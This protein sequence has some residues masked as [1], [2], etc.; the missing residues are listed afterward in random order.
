MSLSDL[1]FRAAVHRA[2]PDKSSAR[3]A[4]L[5]GVAQRTAQ[6]WMSNE[7]PVPEGI[8]ELFRHQGDLAAEY[9]VQAELQAVIDHFL[10]VGGHPE[11][12]GSILSAVYQG[13]LDKPIE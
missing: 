2:L 6:K 10:E 4:R 9:N 5:A 12:A 3:A 7:A 8:A 1:K 11:V 13:L